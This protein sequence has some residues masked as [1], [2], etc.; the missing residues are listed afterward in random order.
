M[1]SWLPGVGAFSL[2]LL[3][4]CSMVHRLGAK[5][6]LPF[7]ACSISILGST[8]V[9]ALISLGGGPVYPSALLQ[10]FAAALASACLV[11]GC[12]STHQLLGQQRRRR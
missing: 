9:G 3:V 12:W 2:A 10:F 5:Q 1:E 6:H 11:A 7:M 8:L 4:G